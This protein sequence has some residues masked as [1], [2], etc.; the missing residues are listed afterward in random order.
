MDCRREGSGPFAFPASP[1]P[2]RSRTLGALSLQPGEVLP[3]GLCSYRFTHT[4]W[5]TNVSGGAAAG[6]CQGI[7]RA[8]LAD[9]NSTEARPH[10]TPP[11][12]TSGKCCPTGKG[13]R[14]LREF[15]CWPIFRLRP[16]SSFR[17]S[18]STSYPTGTGS[19]YLSI[20]WH[21]RAFTDHLSLPLHADPHLCPIPKYH[22]VTPMT[23]TLNK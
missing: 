23:D 7:R 1:G 14:R 11:P 10:P 22:N 3:L 19:Q 13:L 18:A 20:L 15:R 12:L 17:P 4:S 8:R 5:F 16:K 2:G 6:S 21:L 9:K